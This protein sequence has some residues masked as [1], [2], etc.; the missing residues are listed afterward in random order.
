MTPEIYEKE[1]AYIIEHCFDPEQRRVELDK[2]DAER[3]GSAE[4]VNGDLDSDGGEAY[5][6]EE[7]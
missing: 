6:F 7:G 4:A 2:L 5:C 1:K 3:R